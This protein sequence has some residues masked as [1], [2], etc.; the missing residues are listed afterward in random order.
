[1]HAGDPRIGQ[2]LVGRR[3]DLRHGAAALGDDVEAPLALAEEQPAFGVVAEDAGGRPL[4]DGRQRRQVDDAAVEEITLPGVGVDELG[5]QTVAPGDRLTGEI[6]DIEVRVDDIAVVHAIAVVAIADETGC[7]DRAPAVGLQLRRRCGVDR[8]HGRRVV[9]ARRHHH[10]APLA[11]TV[12]VDVDGN[13]ALARYV[14]RTV[15]PAT[16]VAPEKADLIEVGQFWVEIARDLARFG[17]GRVDGV[18]DDQQLVALRVVDR[19]ARLVDDADFRQC[20]P[21]DDTDARRVVRRAVRVRFTHKEAVAFGID[22]D[23]AAAQH[24]DLGQRRRVDH[25]DR[26]LLAF[27]HEGLEDIEPA[28]A[29]VQF[30]IAAEGQRRHGG[31]ARRVEYV[32]LACGVGD[33]EPVARA[34]I[35]EVGNRCTFRRQRHARH[36]TWQC[37]A[38]LGGCDDSRCRFGGSH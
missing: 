7:R 9:P 24:A 18:G 30:E 6:V 32:K 35:A 26:R 33:I 37:A 31:V 12:R 17:I 10:T 23:G 27:A 16:T 4:A 14:P 13:H 8:L 38:R 3:V 36:Q 25:M 15:G 19:R 11:R 1:M 20:R 29:L 28:V 21:V 5:A 34:V 2:G 22:R